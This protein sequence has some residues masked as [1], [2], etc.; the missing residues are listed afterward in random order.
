MKVGGA[1]CEERDV[2]GLRLVRDDGCR[3][4]GQ[5]VRAEGA[6]VR[7]EIEDDGSAVVGEV[8]LVDERVL[9]RF[10]VDLVVGVR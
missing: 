3:A 9:E 10:P 6:L 8:R 1:S 2:S 5:R 7:A 4:V